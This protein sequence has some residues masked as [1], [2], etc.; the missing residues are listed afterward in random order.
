MNVLFAAIAATSVL[1]DGAVTF[2][3]D[4]APILSARCASC[5]HPDGPAPFSLLTYDDARRRASQ[6]A[7]VTGRRY[8]PPWKPEPG[9][10]TFVGER[11]LTDEQIQRIRRWATAG[12]VEGKGSLPAADQPPPRTG[13]W[14]NGEPDLIVTLPVYTLRGDGADVFRNFV[15]PV[16]GPGLRYVRGLEFR[17]GSRAVH[18]ANIR[19][20]P[21]PASRRL[22]EADPA[23]GYEG[24]ILRSADYPD[25]HFL[26]WTPGQSPPLA[27]NGQAWRLDAGSD[28]VVQL[29]LQPTGKPELVQPAIGLYFTREP[30]TE[31]PAILRLGRQ[32]LDIPPGAADYRVVDSYVVPVDVE[33]RAI[34]PHAHYRAREVNAWATLP[35]GSRRWLIRIRNW[36]F[37]WQDQYRYT[38][39]FWLPAGTKLESEYVFDNSVNNPR[40]PDR[41]PR[42]V[43]WG[44]RS[45]DEMGDVWVQVVTRTEHDRVRLNREFRRKMASEDAIGCE[46]LV[47]REPDHVNLRNDA[48][49]LYL[50]LGQAELALKHFAAVARLQPQSPAAHYNVATALEAAGRRDAAVAAYEQAL[51]LDPEYSPAHN[52]LGNLL[53][54]A[55]QVDQARHHYERAVAAQAS[56]AEA[57]NNLGGVL[58]VFRE[59]EAAIDHL[60]EALRLRPAYPEAHFNLARAYA[61]AG[62]FEDAIRTA[63]IAADEAAAFDKPRLSAQIGEELR[64]YRQGRR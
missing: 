34:Q 44:W 15:V 61:A 36:D 60:Q 23:P 16:P 41:P 25:G 37:N 26:G 42:R 27:P 59:I 64:L 46:A 28:L 2:T 21:T 19:I 1:A 58:L 17:P 40:N 29:H 53:L 7:A 63:M 57:H 3:R 51:A 45:S 39:P 50:E 47:A 14:Q 54:D 52:N 55:R 9:F 22:D 33:V 31:T 10:G 11:R 62:R 43:S 56:N 13:V 5:H 35:D 8:M 32:N 49:L 30:P 24:V 48:A 38:S 4:I 6:I 12:A 20:D 18:H